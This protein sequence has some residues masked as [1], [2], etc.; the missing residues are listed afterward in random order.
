[1]RDELEGQLDRLL[2]HVVGMSERTDGMM[3]AALTALDEPDG[4]SA[5]LVFET[6]ELV[7]RAYHEVQNGVLT[8]IALHGPVGRDLRMLTA[9]IHVSLHVERMGDYAKNVARSATSAVR[10]EPEPSLLEELMEM[11][12]LARGV[13]RDGVRSFVHRDVELA[14]DVLRRDDAVDR[15]NLGI[16]H[17]LVRLAANDEASVEWAARMIQVTRQLE[18][19][20]DH[21]VDIAGM[22]RFVGGHEVS[23]DAEAPS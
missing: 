3:G 12:E 5:T 17:R 22:T 2:T 19:Y 23:D 9:L 8:A 20:A 15:L 7:D 16:F 11:G 14:D 4:G 10:D 21:G 13:G 18:R 1:M 6:D